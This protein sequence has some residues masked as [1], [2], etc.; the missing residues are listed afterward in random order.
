MGRHLSKRG[1][2]TA[3]VLGDTIQ[4]LAEGL[5]GL[6]ASSR[7][8]LVLSVGAI[9]QR[10]RSA[11]FLSALLAEWNKYREAGRIKDDYLRTEQHKACLGELLEFLE[12]SIP[13][14]TRFK[15]VK[16]IVLVAA[17]EKLSTR[18]DVMPVQ[19]MRIARDLS[20]AEVLILNACF[21]A[22]QQ[23]F[24]K[25][26]D[27]Y[28]WHDYITQ[29]TGLAYKDLVETHTKV[30]EGKSLLLPPRFGDRSGIPL[31]PYFRLI[32]L[33]YGLCNFINAYEPET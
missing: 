1:D 2:D 11:D 7:K 31:K 20:S 5:T 17:E 33:G 27:H 9:F 30:L 25:G 19:F 28:A 32:E 10:M 18:N 22:S 12:Q 16:Q 8:D 29:E 15:V 23:D 21:K 14:E 3:H 13:D 24:W 6:A 4:A 26:N